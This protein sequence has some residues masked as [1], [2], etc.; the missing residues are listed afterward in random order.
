M[1]MLKK[2][3]E[4]Q[5]GLMEKLAPVER[6][7][8]YS[9]P[10]VPLDFRQRQHQDWFR[11]M[12]WYLTEEIVETLTSGPEEHS[13][14]LADC[15]HFAIELCILSGLDGEEFSRRFEQA[16]QLDL[17][18][19]A[20]EEYSL[21]DVLISLGLA[22]NLLKAKHWKRNPQDTDIPELQSHLFSML[23]RLICVIRSEGYCYHDI[24]MDKHKVNEKRIETNY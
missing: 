6:E 1:N 17:F 15:L 10:P 3:F 5:R 13:S 7:L 14:E 2:L 18:E 21:T 8:G 24:Y 19:E 4:F 22:V 12:S 16:E 9:P 23:Y 11:L 20:P